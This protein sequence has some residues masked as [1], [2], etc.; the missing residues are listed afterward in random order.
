MTLFTQAGVTLPLHDAKFLFNQ[1]L[2]CLISRLTSFF[3]FQIII[4]YIYACINSCSQDWC[5]QSFRC[6]E[7]G[8]SNAWPGGMLA[9]ANSGI[10]KS[11]MVGV[12]RAR[13]RDVKR[14]HP[15][16]SVCCLVC[17]RVTGCDSGLKSGHVPII[18]PMIMTWTLIS[19]CLTPNTIVFVKESWY[20]SAGK[21]SSLCR[22]LIALHNFLR[23]ESFFKKV[24]TSKACHFSLWLLWLGVVAY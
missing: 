6:G 16:T 19:D 22:L 24:A 14:D 11:E 7:H 3:I 1:N 9:H 17:R 10:M 12:W 5:G 13:W 4:T 2:I 8:L 20:C 15:D 23:G 18:I 21:M